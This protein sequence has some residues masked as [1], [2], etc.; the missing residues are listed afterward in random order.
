MSPREIE[1]VK[2]IIARKVAAGDFHVERSAPQPKRQ[3]GRKNGY[4]FSMTPEA[5]RMRARRGRVI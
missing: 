3:G 2:A 1:E 4:R 5:I